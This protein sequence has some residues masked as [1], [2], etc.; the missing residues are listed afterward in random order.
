MKKLLVIAL[1]LLLLVPGSIAEP[2]EHSKKPLSIVIPVR[3]DDC[4]ALVINFITT[5]P[6][7]KCLNFDFIV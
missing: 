2:N 1:I 7:I 3:F 4:N 5:P 6:T